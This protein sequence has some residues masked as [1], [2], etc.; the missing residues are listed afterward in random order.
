M[1][2]GIPTMM[3]YAARSPYQCGSSGFSFDNCLR[4]K[5]LT[6]KGFVEP[7]R[8]ST[9]TTVVGIIFDGGVIIGADSRATNANIIPSNNSRKIYELQHNIFAGG[10]G[11]AQDTSA[12]ME[13]TRAQLELHR[14][15]TGFRKVPVRCANQ[16]VR[17]LLYRFSGNMEANVIIGGV[18]RTGTHLFCTRFDGTTD[19]VP[20]TSLG[21]GN[22]AAM[23]M[24]ESRWTEGLDEQSARDL[25][26]DAVFVGMENDLN[27][28]GRA[29]LCII[30]SDFS[31]HWN[32]Q[33]PYP[34]KVSPMRSLLLAI[35]RGCTTILSTTEH[36]V[37]PWGETPAGCKAPASRPG[38][39][40]APGP[41][42]TGMRRR[43]VETQGPLKAKRRKTE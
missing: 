24:L 29:C 28:G 10:A 41:G 43:G 26:C 8:I 39:R 3:R 9:G 35:R 15:S 23:S 6:E 22:L 20:F 12:L 2:N 21:S 31:V 5:S 32:V 37:V 34:N 38:G 17:Q 13:V 14:M 4:N 11:V 33:S 19:T 42:A 36:Q 27:S 16:M 1:L 7:S 18:D 25:A 40:M 30:R